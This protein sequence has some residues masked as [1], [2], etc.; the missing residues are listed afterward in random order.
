MMRKT[1]IITTL[2]L[3]SSAA[4]AQDPNAGQPGHVGGS[5]GESLNQKQFTDRLPQEEPAPADCK[6]KAGTPQSLLDYFVKF[7]QPIPQQYCEEQQ[8]AQEPPPQEEAPQEEQP[9]ADAQQEPRSAPQE[10]E[11]QAPPPPV[12]PVADDPYAPPPQAYHGRPYPYGDGPPYPGALSPEHAYEHYGYGGY[13]GPSGVDVHAPFFN[14]HLQFN[15]RWR[16]ERRYY[17]NWR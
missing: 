17:R 6:A 11:E 9:Q 3:L 1:L 14:F 8:Q 15:R 2:M 10:S 13:V 12:P 4:L 7:H 5:W 16:Q